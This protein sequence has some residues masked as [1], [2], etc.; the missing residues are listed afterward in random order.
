VNLLPY[1]K[2]EVAGRPHAEMKWRF[3]IS[4]ALRDGDWK[5]VRLPDRLPMLFHLGRDV[6]EQK[7]VALENLERTR[8]ML[9]RLG[10]WD[11]TLPHPVF[12]EGAVWKKRQLD[13]YDRTY[14]LEQPAAPATRVPEP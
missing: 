14:P 12:M 9:K 2:G 7:D 11:V 3:T 10:S 13:L 4:A 6:S 1:V 5:L 8:A